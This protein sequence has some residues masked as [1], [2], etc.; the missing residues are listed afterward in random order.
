MSEIRFQIWTRGDALQLEIG[1]EHGG[2][3][4][5]GPKFSGNSE[6]LASYRVEPYMLDDIRRYLDKVEAN[7]DR[8]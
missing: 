2:Y 7:E 3:R 4:I 6:M 1:D 5:G 8:A